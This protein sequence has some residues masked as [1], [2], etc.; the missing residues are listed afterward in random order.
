LGGWFAG[1]LVCWQHAP[2]K[3]TF[4]LPDELVRRIKIEAAIAAGRE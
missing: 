3:A 4:D 1:K 2:M